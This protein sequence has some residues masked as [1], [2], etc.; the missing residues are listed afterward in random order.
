MCASVSDASADQHH[1]ELATRHAFAF[2]TERLGC[3]Q[4]RIVTKT[5]SMLVGCYTVR[6]LVTCE[7]LLTSTSI[8]KMGDVICVPTPRS[9]ITILLARIPHPMC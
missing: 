8:K 3:Q 5:L 6:H 4:M 7:R 2:S 1:R 9:P